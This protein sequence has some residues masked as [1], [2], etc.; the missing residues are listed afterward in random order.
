LTPAAALASA[1]TLTRLPPALILAGAGSITLTPSSA[2]AG[3]RATA[4]SLA[5]WERLGPG[6]GDHLTFM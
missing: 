5:A 4:V 1:K 2:L 3:A 6:T